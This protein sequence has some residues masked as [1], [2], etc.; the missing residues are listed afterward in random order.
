[1]PPKVKVIRIGADALMQPTR[2]LLAALQEEDTPVER[3]NLQALQ[4]GGP[5]QI[6]VWTQ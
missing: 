2:R 5:G 3:A 6:S 4:L 1:M